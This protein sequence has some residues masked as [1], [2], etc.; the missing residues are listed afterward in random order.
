MLD[1]ST[2]WAESIAFHMLLYLWSVFL[3][4]MKHSKTIYVF[5]GVVIFG[6]VSATTSTI[7]GIILHNSVVTGSLATLNQVLGYWV[8][9]VQL[10]VA[11]TFASF[12]ISFYGKR[13][14]VGNVSPQTVAAL[15]RLTVLALV[16]FTTYVTLGVCNTRA[17]TL[18]VLSPGALATV[19]YVKITAV[20]VRGLALLSVLGL[21]VP[22]KTTT[23]KA[24]ISTVGQISTINKQ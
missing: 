4:Q 23:S 14:G 17:V 2:S 12:G 13:K 20:T 9:L 15:T 16:A 18:S 22:K 6:A 3:M 8:P 5:R 21:R 1:I 7:S 11:V 19:I 10:F 24:A